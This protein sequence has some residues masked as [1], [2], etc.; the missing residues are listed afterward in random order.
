MNPLHPS[1]F[2]PLLLAAALPGDTGPYADLVVNVAPGPAAAGSP[3]QALGPPSGTGL[4]EGSFEVCTLGVGG[5]LTLRLDS[6][7]LDL[8]GTDLV[9]CENPFYVLGTLDSFA[10]VL[11]VEVSSDGTNFARFPTRYTGA[12]GPFSPFTGVPVAAYR[13]FAGV[14]PVLAGPGPALAPLDV[15]LHGGDAFDFADLADHPLVLAGTVNLGAIEYVRLVDAAA[16]IAQDSFG[17]LVW[18]AGIGSTSSADVDAIVAVN[19]VDNLVPGRPRVELSLVAGLLD[20]IIEDDNGL[21]DVKAGLHA[22]VNGY[23]FEFFSLL[24]YFQF[25]ELSATRLHLRTG[26]IPEGP[27]AAVFKISALDQTGL[28][29]GD[30]VVIQ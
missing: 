26:P 14:M 19:N 29:G 21:S 23:A 30:G 13:G 12:A 16:G 10:E 8:A 1:F 28:L 22:S 17:T 11:F 24:P 18:D 2:A 7:A 6:P 4:H 9:V 5:S 27:F 25:I 15:A 20:I 3:D